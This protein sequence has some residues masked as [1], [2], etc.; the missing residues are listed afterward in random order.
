MNTNTAFLLALLAS[1]G[2]L[3]YSAWRLAAC[4]GLFGPMVDLC[5][6][7]CPV[8]L[9]FIVA[10]RRTGS[11]NP[12]FVGRATDE[13]V[14][15]HGGR[16]DSVASVEDDPGGTKTGSRWPLTMSRSQVVVGL[17]ISVAVASCLAAYALVAYWPSEEVGMRLRREC[18]SIIRE[19]GGN[20]LSGDERESR[21]RSCIGARARGGR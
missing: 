15:E 10:M 13:V 1:W 20:N 16:A 21:I 6:L 12:R 18:E 2:F 8:I 19:M 7:L 11:T 14:V 17:W 9:F 4:R 3:S 5:A